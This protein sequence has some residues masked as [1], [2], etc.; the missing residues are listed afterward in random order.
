MPVTLLTPQA[1]AVLRMISITQ[2][3]LGVIISA[4]KNNNHYQPVKHVA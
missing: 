2:A 1:A 4:I 3:A